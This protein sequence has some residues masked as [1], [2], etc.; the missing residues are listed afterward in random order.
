MKS[1]FF[2]LTNILFVVALIAQFSI[3]SASISCTRT[4][5]SRTGTVY[6]GGPAKTTLTPNTDEITVKVAKTGGRAQTIVNIYVNGSR[7]SFIEFNNGNYTSTKTKRV[8][9]VRGKTVRI[10]IVNQSVG[11]KFEYRLTVTGTTDALGNDSGNLAGQGQKTVI[12]DRACKNKVTITIRRTSGQARANVFIYKNG[13][14]IYDEVL[15]K[16][17]SRIVK[18]YSG[19]NNAIYKVVIKNVSV[20][21][22]IGWSVNGRQSN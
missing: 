5:K 20:G 7:K 14:K 12:L 16:N 15:D 13:A 2:Q 8:T 1:S 6:A 21:N 17:E 11:N 4:L 22:F 18:T 10:E 19:A 9:G 3:A